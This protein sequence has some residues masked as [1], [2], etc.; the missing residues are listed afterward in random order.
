MNEHFSSE[1]ISRWTIG[2]RSAQE[3]EHARRCPECAAKLGDLESAIAL[4]RQSVRD[5]GESYGRSEFLLRAGPQRAR[6]GFLSR[7]SRWAPAAAA[8]LLLAAIPIYTSFRERQRQ[9]EMAR[10][11]A[12]LLEQVDVEISRAVPAPMEP[13][14][15]L[16]SWNAS[17]QETNSGNTETG[18]TR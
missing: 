17:A 13:L 8:L 4:F 15:E 9:A 3:Q 2:E 11:D 16:V 5:C 12:A 7:L 10:A 18:E 14:V 6:P 1:Q